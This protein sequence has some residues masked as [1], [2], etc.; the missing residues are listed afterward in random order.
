MIPCCAY[1]GRAMLP[2]PRRYG[3]RNT[4]TCGLKACRKANHRVLARISARRRKPFVALAALNI[5]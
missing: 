1:C 2:N 4:K 3:R 5:S